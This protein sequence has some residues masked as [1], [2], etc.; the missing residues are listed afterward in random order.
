VR[1]S[2]GAHLLQ[3]SPM[4]RRQC[5]D[6]SDAPPTDP[7]AEHSAFPRNLCI[8]AILHRRVCVVRGAG[9]GQEMRCMCVTGTELAAQCPRC[10]CLVAPYAKTR[11]CVPAREHERGATHPKLQ[12]MSLRS[13]PFPCAIW[14]GTIIRGRRDCGGRQRAKAVTLAAVR[15]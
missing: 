9:G 2:N 7:T 4:L 11:R 1:V 8:D 5:Y 3:F 10:R 6:T 13:I 15:D 14:V 12:A